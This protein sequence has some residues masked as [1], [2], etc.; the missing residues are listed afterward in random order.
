MNGIF[1]LFTDITVNG[2]PLWVVLLIC[3]GVFLASFMDAIAGGGCETYYIKT[4]PSVRRRGFLLFQLQNSGKRSSLPTLT[5]SR[6]STMMTVGRTMRL[7]FLMARP[8][9]R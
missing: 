2:F 8:A 7:P 9:P 3:V 4:A 1:S 6:I 5:V